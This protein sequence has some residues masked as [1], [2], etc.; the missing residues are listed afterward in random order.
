MNYESSGVDLLIPTSS[1]IAAECDLARGF[2]CLTTHRSFDESLTTSLSDAGQRIGDLLSDRYGATP[3]AIAL[4]HQIHG[5]TVRHVKITSDRVQKLPD[6]DGLATESHGA[7]LAIRTADCLPVVLVDPVER[8]AACLH[9]GWRGTFENIVGAGVAALQAMGSTARNMRCWVG[10]GI[11]GECYEVSEELVQQFDQRFSTL[12]DF[13]AGRRLN[14]PALNRLQALAAGIPES[15]VV[16]SGL[17][18]FSLPEEFHSHRRQGR[19]RGHL[20]TVC[21]FCH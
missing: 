14:L 19:E 2:V 17:C 3:T 9:A 20:Y 5:G 13:S 16:M 12:G 15:S 7:F 10:P 4:A 21:G 18:T 6:C 11:S 8:R 1:S